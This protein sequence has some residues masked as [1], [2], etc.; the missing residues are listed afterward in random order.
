M[1][2]TD[3]LPPLPAPFETVYDHDGK[4][5]VPCYSPTQMEG[6]ARQAIAL[7]APAAPSEPVAFDGESLRAECITWANWLSGTAVQQPRRPLKALLAYLATSL[8]TPQPSAKPA[9]AAAQERHIED[10]QHWTPE[11]AGAGEADDTIPEPDRVKWHGQWYRREQATPP[12]AHAG[13]T[14]AD[15]PEAVLAEAAKH[16]MSGRPIKP[17]E[18]LAWAINEA[19]RGFATTPAP[20]G[21]VAPEAETRDAARYRWLRDRTNWDVLPVDKGDDLAEWKCLFHSPYGMHH[22]ADD[23]LD[24]AID[25]AMASA[26][27]AAQGAPVMAEAR[28]DRA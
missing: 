21:A 28:K 6:Y 23:N 13:L 24:Q 15:S 19:A 5:D 9:G 4:E 10:T 1:T 18:H 12:A 20:V 26:P 16:L 2:H 27:L 7:A 3:N 25:S 22:E 14:D 8:A 17:G 11:P